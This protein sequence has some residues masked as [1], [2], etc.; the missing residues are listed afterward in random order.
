MAIEK[1]ILMAAAFE[2]DSTPS[3]R[4]DLHNAI[5]HFAH[6]TF[7]CDM[8]DPHSIELVHFGNKRWANYFK[9]VLLGLQS[10]LPPEVRQN[11]HGTIKVLVDGTV[12]P[13]S[14]LSSSAAMT[15]CSSIVILTALQA[16][17]VVPRKVIA[18]VACHSE[19]LVGVQSGG[20]DQAVSVF[21]QR[22]M[23]LFVSFAPTLHVSPVELPLG[24]QYVFL[25]TNT[26]I[27]SDK[28]ATAPERYNLRVVE[29]RLAAA[30]LKR[31]LQTKSDIPIQFR[32]TLR[33]VSD[34]FWA[35]H[36][37]EWDKIL[38]EFDDVRHACHDLGLEA[39]HLQAMLNIVEHHIP[40]RG[41]SREEVENLVGIH[42]AD[43]DHHFLKDFHI[44][45]SEFFLHAR[46]FHVYSEA[47][48]VLQFHAVLQRAHADHAQGPP[49]FDPH[50][51]ARRLGAIMNASHE[52]LCHDYDCSSPEL[53]LVVHIARQHGSLGSRLTGAGWGGCAIH[54]VHRDQVSTLMDLFKE[55]YYSIKFGYMTEHMLNDAM[56]LTA[57][58]E[59]ACVSIL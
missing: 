46:A 37:D 32:D 33:S 59:G 5:T 14:S 9:V 38:H 12:P 42:G 4:C 11:A 26:M 54:L 30:V 39:G 17:H 25:V 1:D 3:L 58:G 53:N 21:G 2:P 7:E 48:R 56:F 35:G 45:A 51:V 41:L 31:V 16:L 10:V 43:F 44:R 27:K 20:M 23:A 49:H 50:R 18:D 34:T 24:N 13:E 15:T 6:S 52:S 55:L 28:K 40:R 8:T 36:T 47:L 22:D 19:R 29:T 57:P